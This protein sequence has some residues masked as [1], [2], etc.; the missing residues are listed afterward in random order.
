M[1]SEGKRS[2]ILTLDLLR[3]YFLFVIIIDHIG[4]FPSIFE[5]VT[6]RGEL[7]ASAAEGFF[8]I[9]GLLVG[10]IYGPRMVKNVWQTVK[11]IWQRAFLLYAI[12][13]LLTCLF[14]WW[15]NQNLG[16]F[17]KEGL[18]TQPQL[19]EFFYKTLTLQYFYGWA[20]FLPYYAVFMF[21]AP[22]AVY[23]CTK[24]LGWLVVLASTLIWVFRGANF[25]MAWQLLFMVSL[26]AGW[27]LPKIEQTV[28]AL[29]RPAKLWLKIGTYSLAL[30]FILLSALSIRVANFVI[31]DFNGFAAL[32]AFMQAIF[33]QL[34]QLR[35]FMT[36]LI[37]KWS[38][39][40][41]RLFTAVVW[42]VALYIFVRTREAQVNRLTK[43]F[44]KILGER[45]L[46]VYTVHSVVIFALILLVRNPRDFIINS[47][48]TVPV[49]ALIFVIARYWPL[50][51]KRA[52]I[53]LR[54]TAQ[55]LKAEEA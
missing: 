39:E 17:V 2:R 54:L 53:R 23:A 20:D 52:K 7:W 18:W 43:G 34:D 8:I 45:S 28:R 4:F 29:P 24:R 44:F 40:P 48:L 12:S 1:N 35:D 9:S 10:Y 27:Y 26:V 21:W 13:I 38:L 47:I 11:K 46:I 15:G 33:F 30:A 50:V 3:G 16:G 42:F 49:V 19:G 55:R 5:F 25:E 31:Y 6:G 32:P 36:P 37:V 14:V 22:L 51:H 41:V